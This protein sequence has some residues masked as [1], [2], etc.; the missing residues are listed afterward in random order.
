[1]VV[2]NIGVY[3]KV[4]QGN[5]VVKYMSGFADSVLIHKVIRLDV[6]TLTT[7]IVDLERL[8]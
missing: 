7:Q 3:Q 8:V 1:M 4:E 2:N 5:K 6:A